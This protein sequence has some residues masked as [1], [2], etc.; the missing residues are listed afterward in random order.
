MKNIIPIFIL[1]ALIAVVYSNSFNTSLHFDDTTNI[2]RNVPVHLKDFTWKNVKKT[3]YGGGKRGD[4][5]HPHLYR[6]VAVFSFALNYYFHELEVF[7]YHLV[8]F[9]IHTVASIF[10]FLF[11][12]QILDFLKY[13]HSLPIALISTVLW[14]LNPIQVTSVTYITQRMTSMAGMFYIMAMYFYLKGRM[15]PENSSSLKYW[16]TSIICVTLAL[17]CKENAIMV[18]FSIFLF[19]LIF[20][21]KKEN[22]KRNV[23]VFLWIILAGILI[24]YALSGWETLSYNQL[25]EGYAKR[26]FTLGQRLLTGPRVI[27]FYI[28]LLV[29]PY[30]GLLSLTHNLVVSKSLIDPLATLVALLVLATIITL[31]IVKIRKYPLIS[32][33]VL[34]FFLNHLIEVSIFPLELVFEHRNY[35]PS[36]FFF[37][38]FSIL[39]LHIWKNW[40]GFK[41]M[42][43]ALASSIILFFGYNTY[44]QNDVWETDLKLWIDTTKKSPDPRSM[45]NYGGAFYS[46][47]IDNKD[48]KEYFQKALRYWY[49]SANFNKLFGTNYREDANVLPYGRVMYMARHNA[50]MLRMAKEGKIRSAWTIKGL[51]DPD[52]FVIK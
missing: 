27:L 51:P 16:G 18:F 42:V 25:M 4:I 28:M 45:F 17:G 26:D 34:F 39:L 9:L 33:C 50:L 2:I 32:Y 19:D 1:L 38:P 30:H 24:I 3:F 41:V 7:G 37:L 23:M 5:Y 49:I 48:K 29:F 52:R 10:L 44:Y 20:I 14:A 6:P 15:S 31:A 47:W 35:I 8:N 40:L 46:L 12:K 21:P 22:I 13:P 11:I 43:P 36:F